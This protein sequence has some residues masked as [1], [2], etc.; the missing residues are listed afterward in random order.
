MSK[1]DG[2]FCHSMFQKASRDMIVLLV[3]PAPD[4]DIVFRPAPLYRINNN[5][6]W[7]QVMGF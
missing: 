6:K 4:P 2:K 5:L 7:V 3:K 1:K